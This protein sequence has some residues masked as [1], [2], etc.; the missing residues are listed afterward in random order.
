MSRTWR[1]PSASTRT[2]I[3][4]SSSAI[5]DQGTGPRALARTTVNF[6]ARLGARRPSA[7]TAAPPRS[8]WT[9]DQELDVRSDCA[10]RMS[11]SVTI[12]AMLTT[13]RVAAVALAVLAVLVLFESRKLPLGSLHNPGPAYMSVLLALAL[14]AFAILVA[15][16]GG[17]GRGLSAV[18]RSAWRP[19]A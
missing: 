6:P 1:G 18:G 7:R 12:P 4:W 5:V 11:L 19:R 14:L 13:N 2:A 8:P 17:A 10:A 15:V 16:Y 9:I 3:S